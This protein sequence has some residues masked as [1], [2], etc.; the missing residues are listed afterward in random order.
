MLL[1]TFLTDG[2]PGTGSPSDEAPGAT[3]GD[4]LREPPDQPSDATTD[5]QPIAVTGQPP[6]GVPDD[7]EP[8]IVDTVVD[9]DTIRVI[10]RPGGSIPE[11]GS[12]R[13]R[14]LNVDAP[15]LGGDRRDPACG[16][17][18]ATRY[19][20]SMIE[21]ED[22]VWL[23]ADQEDRDRFGRPLRGMWTAGGRFLNERLAEAGH[24]DVLLVPP[25]DRFHDRI[26]AAVDR[27]RA[28]NRGI[29][30]SCRG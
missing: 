11:G 8:A 16:A 29:W 6:D 12:I 2:G 19:L 24:A 15:E 17:V 3:T 22:V 9:G 10:A 28:A 14:L 27:A 18:E 23:A 30:G 5:D 26:A 13:I 21:R 4:Q 20:A 25:N 1:A 7:A